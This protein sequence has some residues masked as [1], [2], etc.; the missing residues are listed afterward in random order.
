[1]DDLQTFQL[2]QFSLFN[3]E[4]KVFTTKSS[5][6]NYYV[7]IRVPGTS[8]GVRKSLKTKDEKVARRLAEDEYINIRG[9]IQAGIPI[10]EPKLKELV[11]QFI[12]YKTGHVESKVI[13]QGRL[14]TIKSQL[15]HLER[16]VG[17][18][19]NSILAIHAQGDYYEDYFIFRRKKNPEV[20][21][22]TLINEASTITAVY[23]RAIKKKKIPANTEPEFPPI[24]K[25]GNKREALTLDQLRKIYYYMRSKEFLD[26]DKENLHRHFI[27]DFTLV[28]SNTG[29]RFGEAKKLKWKHVQII[30]GKKDNDKYS[31]LCEIDLTGDMTKTGKPRTVQG[32]GGYVFERIKSYSRYTKS[33]DYIFVDNYSGQELDRHYFYRSWKAM[34]KATKLDRLNYDVSYYNL[35]HTY[36]TFRIYAGTDAFILAKNMGTGLQFLQ[37]HYAQ[38]KTRLQRK[39]LTQDIDDPELKSILEEE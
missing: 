37:D 10:F 8:N 27:R 28:L 33:N 9:K 35:R 26:Y 24:K 5:G 34:L 3:G 17:D 7:K 21:N 38:P 16:F 15:K 22:T 14:T 32:R 23:R 39:E 11:E 30:K 19:W 13:T 36:A 29:L 31:W 2:N 4:V 1:M 25:S 20:D 12:E 6:G 18:R